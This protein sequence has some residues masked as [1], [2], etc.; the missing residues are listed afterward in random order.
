[1]RFHKQ[2]RGRTKTGSKTVPGSLRKL[3]LVGKQ[4]T[5]REA[6]ELFQPSRYCGCGEN[7]VRLSY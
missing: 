4:V 5:T 1:M 7:G 3:H 2:G 6:Y